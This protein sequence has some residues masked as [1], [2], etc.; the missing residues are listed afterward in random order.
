MLL[1]IESGAIYSA[2]LTIL[3]ILYKVE[4][5]FQYVIVDAVRSTYES[6]VSLSYISRPTTQVS[7]IVV[8]TSSALNDYRC[9]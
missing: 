1:V 4:S 8:S 6:F 2:T 3:I 9:V 7:P 5:W